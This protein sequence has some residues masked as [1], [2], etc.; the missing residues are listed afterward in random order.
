MTEKQVQIGKMPTPWGIEVAVYGIP[1]SDDPDSYSMTLEDS[2]VMAGIWRPSDRAACKEAMQAHIA[3]AGD[4]PF[5]I[6]RRFGGGKIETIALTM[7]ARSALIYPSIPTDRSLG[8]TT[9]GDYSLRDAIDAWVTTVT[10]RHRWC[11]RATV[12]LELFEEQLKVLALLPPELGG[13]AA[14]N[15]LTAVLENMG[16]TEID[17][18]ESASF[19][20]LAGHEAWSHAAR[21]WLQPVRGT[22]FGDWIA[23]RPVYRQLA[24]LV[25]AATKDVPSWAIEVSR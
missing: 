4:V 11:D 8:D 10:D 25:Q 3:K 18:L 1:G 5:E 15:M 24:K 17:C 22:W 14:S 6:F 7:P 9:N 20:L 23:Q 19:F 2:M 21:S 16:E 13:L 12:L